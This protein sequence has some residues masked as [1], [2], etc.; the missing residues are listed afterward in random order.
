MRDYYT[1]FPNLLPFHP[2]H[3]S[4]VRIRPLQSTLYLSIVT[5][6]TLSVYRVIDAIS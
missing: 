5:F 1:L 4:Q 3:L 6:T 2:A